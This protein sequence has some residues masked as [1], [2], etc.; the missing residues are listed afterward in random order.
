MKTVLKATAFASLI[1]LAA[2]GGKG[3][4]ALAGNVEAAADNSADAIDAMAD[5][6]VNEVAADQLENKAD[7]IRD[8]GEAKADAIDAADVN[9][10]AL[11]NSAVQ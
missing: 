3:D 1:A 8:A 2:C 4:D 6:T 9:A 10:A 7:A 5:N 11:N